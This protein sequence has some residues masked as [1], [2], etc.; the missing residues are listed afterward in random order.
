MR[1]LCIRFALILSLV[2]E[3]VF[4]VRGDH[5]YCNVADTSRRAGRGQ[6]RGGK[7]RWLGRNP[8]HN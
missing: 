3:Y 5:S 2:A 8:H 7:K 6:K 1:I 4:S